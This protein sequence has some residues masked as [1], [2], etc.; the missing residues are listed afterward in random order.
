[1]RMVGCKTVVEKTQWHA[2]EPL[3]YCLLPTVAL[4][5]KSVPR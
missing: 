3:S 1:M 5:H 2:P 4:L